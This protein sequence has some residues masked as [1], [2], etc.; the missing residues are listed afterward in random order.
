MVSPESRVQLV[1]QLESEI[2]SLRDRLGPHTFDIDIGDS[3]ST[4][5]LKRNIAAG[6]IL[7]QIHYNWSRIAL[8]APFL[9]DP[10]LRHSSLSICARAAMSIVQ[11]HRH[12]VS[13]ALL[14]LPWMQIRRMTIS[15]YII[16]IAFW[17]GEITKMEC[18]QAVNSS[19]E[20]LC[21]LGTRWRSATQ[22]R[23]IVVQLADKSGKPP[24]INRYF[25][26]VRFDLQGT[27]DG[28]PCLPDK[29]KFFLLLPASDLCQTRGLLHLPH[30]L[31]RP[32]S[33]LHLILGHLPE[34]HLS[35]TIHQERGTFHLH[36]LVKRN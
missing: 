33:L 10:L 5:P 15:I 34:I 36:V 24:V 27:A 18:E 4:D 11:F 20:V 3:T 21:V 12:V 31:Y 17:R 6:S 25:A 9:R 32:R 28:G 22:V 14:N 35:R 16:F 13:A 29:R 2:D 7:R 30:P 23:Q 26:N 1:L 19:L 8:R